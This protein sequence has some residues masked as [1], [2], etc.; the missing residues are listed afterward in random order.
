VQP[1]DT[2]DALAARVLAQECLIY[3]RVIQ[4]IA[5]GRLALAGGRARFDG[6]ELAA[7]LDLAQVPE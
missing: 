7:P 2:P 1:G 6:R 4:W 5:A 3:P